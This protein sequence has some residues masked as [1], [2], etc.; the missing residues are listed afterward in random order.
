MD[1]IRCQGIAVEN[2]NDPDPEKN[3]APEIIYL[4]Q[5]E[6]GYSWRLEGIICPRRSKNLNNTYSA[7]NNY[8]REDVINMTKLEMFLIFY[9]LLTI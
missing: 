2:N 1:D 3:P 5:L 4:Q 9:F 6:E 7:F 8:S